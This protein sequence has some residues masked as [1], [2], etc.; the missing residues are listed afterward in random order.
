MGQHP[1]SDAPRMGVVLRN[2]EMRQSTPEL[3]VN[4]AMTFMRL[5]LATLRPPDFP[6]RANLYA[7]SV[8][9]RELVLTHGE[10]AHKELC[11][12]ERFGC[13]RTCQVL[14]ESTISALTVG[15][16]RFQCDLDNCI[17][18]YASIAD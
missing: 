16:F 14:V 8:R 17:G 15:V 11:P 5:S 2:L 18:D 9:S 4:E 1:A 12:Y 6:I 7:C 10:K 13:V 3:N